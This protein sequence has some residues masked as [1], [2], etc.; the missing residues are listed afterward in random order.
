MNQRIAGLLVLALSLLVIYLLLRGALRT[1][2]RPRRGLNAH[3]N[4]DGSSKR[5]YRSASAAAAAAL[6][7]QHDFGQRMNP[8]RCAEGDHWHI[9]HAH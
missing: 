9:G 7:Y 2:T 8:Y 4:A 1:P 6:E 3:V 5:S